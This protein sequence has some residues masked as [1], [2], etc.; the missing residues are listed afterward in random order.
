[1]SAAH[2]EIIR[3]DATGADG[4]SEPFQ[5]VVLQDK[6]RM[7]WFMVSDY[8]DAD[9]ARSAAGSLAK[10]LEAEPWVSPFATYRDSIL[11][12]GIG[13]ARMRDLVMDL[14]LADQRLGDTWLSA[15][16]EQ[17]LEIAL[18]LKRSYSLLGENDKAFMALADEIRNRRKEA[19]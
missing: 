1:M 19:E 12:A 10:Q 9:A 4:V 15:L 3:L 13:G 16:D 17:H 6:L 18:C 2:V 8:P 11:A 7:G 5:F 14:W